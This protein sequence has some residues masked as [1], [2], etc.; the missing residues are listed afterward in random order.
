LQEGGCDFHGW[1]EGPVDPFVA[2]L[3]VDL[4]NIV[5]TLKRQKEAL[6]MAMGDAAMKMQE[7]A[8]MVAQCKKERDAAIADKE[9]LMLRLERQRKLKHNCCG[10]TVAIFAVLVFLCAGM[11][12]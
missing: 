6:N 3:L 8:A 9:E 7:Q 10:F 11:K 4:R 2:S 12:M 5:W 1:Y